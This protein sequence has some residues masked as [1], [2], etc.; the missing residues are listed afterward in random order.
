MDLP[1]SSDYEYKPR[2]PTATP[3]KLITQ[4]EFEIYVRLCLQPCWIR[5]IPFTHECCFTRDSAVD[6][7][8]KL[9]KFN[10]LLDKQV[11]G[12]EHVWG[13]QARYVVSAVRV[14]IIHALILFVSFGLWIWWQWRHPDDLQGAAVPLTVAGVL[15]STFWASAG[16]LKILR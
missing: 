8:D 15:M 4:H 14:A 12:A 9:P 10:K 16:V 13:I 5:L 2:P 1:E 6:Y 7:V 3:E 11:Q